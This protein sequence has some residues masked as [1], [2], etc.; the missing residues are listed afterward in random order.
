MKKLEP[1]QRLFVLEYLRD[2]NA[3]QAAI[4]AGYSKKT[5][6]SQAADNL[7]KPN[8]KREIDKAIKKRSQRT[9]ITAD[10]VLNELSIIA[11]SD[12]KN[13]IEINDDT[14]AMRAKEFREM[15]GNSSR[16]LEMIREDR[17]I[18]EDSKGNDS[19]INEKVTFKLHS[20]TAALEMLAKHL[21]LYERDND[22]RKPSL[23]KIVYEGEEK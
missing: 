10:M 18:R 3:T 17:M 8:I 23:F 21:G 5:A 15:P 4:R 16:A 1:R 11:F 7:T 6:R 13:H 22:Q 12:L 14:G 19:I 20:K 2:L 9:E